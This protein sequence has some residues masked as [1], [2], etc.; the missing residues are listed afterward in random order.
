MAANS[1]EMLEAMRAKNL[2]KSEVMNHHVEPWL[3]LVECLFLFKD[4]WQDWKTMTPDE[5]PDSTFFN[6]C[7]DP[8]NADDCP[9]ILF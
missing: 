9:H 2:P 3:Q 1:H 6:V 8:F 4:D 5:Y 7:W